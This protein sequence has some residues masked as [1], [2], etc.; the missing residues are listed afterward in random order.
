MCVR[1]SFTKL[2]VTSPQHCEVSITQTGLCHG[3]VMWWELS[4]CPG[5]NLSTSPWNR[6]QVHLYFHNFKQK[7]WQ[8]KF[9]VEMSTTF[10]K[11]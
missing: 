1:F 5:V 9:S 6:T 7:F 4:L 3:V 2:P 11:N 8:E 10:G